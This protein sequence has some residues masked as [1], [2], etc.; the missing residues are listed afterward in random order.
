M[1]LNRWLLIVI[2]IIGL[3]I[4]PSHVFGNYQAK[5]DIHLIDV[6]Q[7]DSILIKTPNHKI[8]LIDGGPPKAGKKVVQ[9][10]KDQK[11]EQIDLIVATHP[12]MDHIGGLPH[13]MKEIKVKKILDSGKIHPTLAY[14]K[15]MNQIWKQKIPMEIAKPNKQIFL[16]SS[17][18]TEILNAHERMKNNN[19]SSIAL[20][21]SYDHINFLFLSDIEVPQEKILAEKYDV[22][23][24]FVKIAHHGSKTSSS[25]QFLKQVNPKIALL[26][27]G[28]QN[29]YGHPVNEVIE[30]LSTIGAY[31]YSTAVFGDVVIHTNG[32]SFLM[33]TERSS[34]DDLLDQAN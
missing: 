2:I 1:H 7:G 5:M 26:S 17:L 33:F 3:A 30:N 20:K 32:K 8:I 6:G 24:D 10:L 34:M 27:Y 13:V 15:Y 25:L 23:A 12:H 11:V 29:K 14:A 16:D 4:F 19:Q 31:I 21:I 18:K 28:K 9:Y 22:E